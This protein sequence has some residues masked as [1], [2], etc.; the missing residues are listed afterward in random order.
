MT[1]RPESRHTG[2]TRRQAGFHRLLVTCCAKP[3]KPGGNLGKD[4]PNFILPFNE[5]GKRARSTRR[6]TRVD[7]GSSVRA[8]RHPRH[9]GS[10]LPFEVLPYAA[11]DRPP[12][13]TTPRA[14]AFRSAS[15]AEGR[16]ASDAELLRYGRRA[17]GRRDA[18]HRDHRPARQRR[19]IAPGSMRTGNPTSDATRVVE[20]LDAASTSIISIWSR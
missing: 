7:P 3:G 8:R 17:P 1:T 12:R 13:P 11:T 5:T 4:E 9:N 18:G 10:G 19:R 16:C 15:R 2:R 14:R 6:I 20:R